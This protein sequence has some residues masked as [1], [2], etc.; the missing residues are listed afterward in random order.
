[1]IFGRAG[2]AP[3]GTVANPLSGL[4]NTLFEGPNVLGG[5]GQPAAQP[6]GPT[7]VLQRPQQGAQA[8]GAMQIGSAGPRLAPNLGAPLGGA[9]AADF[10]N[11]NVAN[12]GPRAGG[13]GGGM[14]QAAFADAQQHQHSHAMRAAAHQ[15]QGAGGNNNLE[16]AWAG[17]GASGPHFTGP[18]VGGPG[19]MMMHGGGK[20]GGNLMM[21]MQMQMQQMQMQMEQMRMQQM[22]AQAP[23]PPMMMMMQSPPAQSLYPPEGYHHQQQ[24]EL[25]HE[26]AAMGAA[27]SS[28][29]ASGAMQSAAADIAS[30]LASH[31]DPKYAASE[32]HAFASQV[33][34]HEKQID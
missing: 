29:N 7:M 5:D 11:G 19:G 12:M 1:M 28:N 23:P 17:Q 9:W 2:C 20:G 15:V 16:A 26:G 8:A 30:E 13:D 27:E 14:M 21:M 25:L 24:Q 31:P 10:Q 18:Q 33:R 22:H 4:V 32:L 34:T 6:Y 3:D